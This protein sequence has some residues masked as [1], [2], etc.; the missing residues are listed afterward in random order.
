[1]LGKTIKNRPRI[2]KQFYENLSPQI[3]SITFTA[4]LR[5]SNG[6]FFGLLPR[7]RKENKRFPEH[8]IKVSKVINR[9]L[10][11]RAIRPI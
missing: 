8:D 11:N 7:L 5:E 2:G 6:L 9:K 3:S 10:S 1:M 4:F